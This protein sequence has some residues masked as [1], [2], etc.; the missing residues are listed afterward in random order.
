MKVWKA[1]NRVSVAEESEKRLRT[2]LR[3]ARESLTCGETPHGD[4][5]TVDIIDAALRDMPTVPCEHQWVPHCTECGLQGFPDAAR[6]PG[7][8]AEGT[9][10]GVK[11]GNPWR[12]P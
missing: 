5:K 10:D 1:K 3:A 7:T 12:K 9:V 11:T 6:S 2:A 4:L 8:V